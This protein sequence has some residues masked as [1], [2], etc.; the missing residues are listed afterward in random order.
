[1]Q[2]FLGIKNIA[3]V[4]SISVSDKF[5][6]ERLNTLGILKFDANNP[7][8]TINYF[9]TKESI[10][11]TYGVG[12]EYDFAK[13]YFGFTSKAV[14]T[15]EILGFYT[16][17]ENATSAYLKGARSPSITELKKLNGKF[18]ISIDGD[19]QDVTLDLSGGGINSYDNV[20]SAIQTA[21][22]AVGSGGFSSATCIYSTITNGFI[23]GTGT[24]GKTS[25]ISVISSPSG[26]TDIS[27]GLGLSA[28]DSIEIVDGK[29]AISTLEEALSDIESINGNYYVVTPLF[30]FAGGEADIAI[31]GSWLKGSKGRYLGI[32]LWDNENL[33]VQGSG[34]TDSL[35]GYDGLYIDFKKSSVQNAF[36]SAI[37][38]SM[39]LGTKGGYYNIN[40]NGADEFLDVAVSTQAEFDGMNANRANSFYVFGEIGQYV[41]SYGQGHLMG[42]IDSANVYINNSYLKIQMQFAVANLFESVGVVSL[43]GGSGVSLLQSSLAP[44]FNNAVNNG[45]II[46][47]T[48][49]TT[50]KNVVTQNFNN[51][52]DAISSLESN[53]WYLE[54]ASVD[55]AKKQITLNYAY[56]A[57]APAN[58]V[59]IKSYILGA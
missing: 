39:S 16:W 56:I 37:I 47:D 8:A 11:S 27:S 33:G 12:I 5:S 1:M 24:T 6:L 7:Q 49:T 38:S 58:K 22:Q 20:A 14:T 45:L 44:I 55:I 57:N 26:G 21:L 2:R 25:S 48:L 10:L 46:V 28:V 9:F 29:D 17:N 30:S 35:I 18:K 4:T 51:P 42:D 36:S 54:L 43:R 50:E 19:A 15:P 52:T 3:D 40:F 59:V 23:I 34:A 31:F 32:Y 13:T 41:V 53:G